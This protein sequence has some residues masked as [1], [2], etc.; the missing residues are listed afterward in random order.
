MWFWPE[1]SDAAVALWVQP[2]GPRSQEGRPRVSL[3]QALPEQRPRSLPSSRATAACWKACGHPAVLPEA[4][5][6]PVSLKRLLTFCAG[7]QPSPSV[8][9]PKPRRRREGTVRITRYCAGRGSAHLTHNEALKTESLKGGKV[10]VLKADVQSALPPVL[11][12]GSRKPRG[13][14][15]PHSGR[16]GLHSPRQFQAP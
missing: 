5:S 9:S 11:E 14:R 16:A 7:T 13:R 10:R 1:P 15:A 12:R 6:R 2:W 8:P 4:V 3:H